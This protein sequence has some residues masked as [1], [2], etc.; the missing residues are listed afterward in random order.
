MAAIFQIR[1]GTTDISSSIFDGELYLNKSKN[2]LQVSIGDGNPITL[3]PLNTASVGD[4]YLNGNITA[5]NAYFSGD[6]AI[7]GNLFLGNNSSDNI[8]ALGVF[9][10]NLVPGTTNTYDVGTTSAVWANVYANNVSASSITGAFS[11]TIGGINITTFS[12]SVDN[13]LDQLETNTGSQDGRIT[14]LENKATTLQTYTASVDSRLNQ[15]STDTGSQNTRITDLENKANTL[16]TYTA[17]VDSRLNQLS[18]DTGSQNSRL[19]NLEATSASL[20]IETSNLESFTAS[21]NNAIDVTGGNTRIKGNLIVDGTQTSLNTTEAFIEDKSITLASGSTT[22]GIADGA[23]FNIAGANVSMSWQDSNTR[24]F[25]N[26]NIAALGSISSSTIVGLNNASVSA[27]STSV[28]SRLANLQTTSGSV[29]G[30]ITALN[31]FSASQISKDST[32][33]TYTASLDNTIARLREATASLNTF[34]SSATIRLNN[35]ESTS[36][37]LLVETSNLE[38]FSAS[39]LLRLNSLETDSGS[40]NTRITVLE[41]KATTLAPLTSSILS[42]TSSANNRLSRLEESTASLN[43]FTG[44]TYPTFSQSVDLRLDDLEY[45]AS[46][47]I[48]A[49]L[50]TALNQIN[51]FTASATIRLN[52]LE[53][54]SASVN[55]RLDQLSN[56]SGSQNTRITTLETK[57][58]TLATVTSSLLIET[59]NLELF[60][61]SALLRLSSLET[62]TGSQNTRITTLENKATTLQTY[63]ASVD[64]R[65]NQLSTDSGSQAGRISNLESFTS[66]INTTIKTKLDVDGVISGSIQ[67]LGGSSIHSGSAGDYQFNS[68]GVGTAP[69]TVAGEIRAAGDIT[70]FYSSDSRLKY[71]VV[72]IENALQKVESIS[73][74]RYHW[75]EGFEDVHSH[76]GSDIGVIAQEIQNILPEVVT[77]RD[78]G[79]LAVNYEKLVPLLIEAIKE[80]SQKVKKLENK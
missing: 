75:K 58:T 3:V 40:Q 7:S 39:A 79:Y 65:L 42:F 48:G 29:N 24:L 71:G 55:S 8:A 25:F 47:S 73:G 27:Y 31:A 76:K 50:T 59:A 30:S 54:T 35:L 11:G 77:E 43:T 69:S 64:S 37:S 62:D 15:L 68:I 53:T 34:T 46:I 70:A 22:S 13:R 56:D 10:T 32:L 23:G 63:T 61:S 57:A 28:D 14:V 80:L 45:T 2:S 5:S 26:T 60:S 78:S 67:V 66:S 41:N 49:G 20:L 72:P 74:N 38:L 17:S 19:N 4:I 18:V 52:N 21:I 12:Q 9:T 16:Q 33:Q 6:V 51:A 36:A 1:R 44:S